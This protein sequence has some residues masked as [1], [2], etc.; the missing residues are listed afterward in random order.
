MLANPHPIRQSF[1]MNDLRCRF[2]DFAHRVGQRRLIARH[3]AFTGLAVAALLLLLS[4][5]A[6]SA[7]CLR[8]PANGERWFDILR[9]GAVVGSQGFRFSRHDGRFLVRNS[10]DI[11]VR[12]S[13]TGLYRYRHN[14][15]ESWQAGRLEAFVGDTE[16]GGDSYLVRAERIDGVFRGR[17]NGQA[18]TVSGYVM[19]ASFWH[20]DTPASPVLWDGGDGLVKVVKSLDLGLER[21]EV[22][23]KML[24]ARRFDLDGQIRR[25]LWYDDHCALVRMSF[26]ARDGSEFVARLR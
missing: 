9:N 21:I 11:Q 18:F 12:E 1:C 15:E 6:W 26:F 13:V 22:R 2:Q 3:T 25:S 19:P 23:G 24:E 4:N 10:V 20:R 17:V 5:P 7:E 8:F 14:A 16:D